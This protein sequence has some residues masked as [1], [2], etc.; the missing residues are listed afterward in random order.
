M[1]QYE[2]SGMIRADVND[3]RFIRRVEGACVLLRCLLYTGISKVCD[4]SVTG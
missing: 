2:S 4:F 1:A 3:I